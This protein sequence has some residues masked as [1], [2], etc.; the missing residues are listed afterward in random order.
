MCL[1]LRQSTYQITIVKRACRGVRHLVAC[2]FAYHRSAISMRPERQWPRVCVAR[3]R[4]LNRRRH[5]H[6]VFVPPRQPV[7][8]VAP[9]GGMECGQ[10]ASRVF[11]RPPSPPC[12]EPRRSLSSTGTSV[13]SGQH[14]AVSAGAASPP[15]AES[16]DSASPSAFATRSTRF[17][18]ADNLATRHSIRTT[19]S[20]RPIAWL[21]I[22]CHP[23]VVHPPPA[24]AC[25]DQ[26]L[27]PK[28]KRTYGTQGGSGGKRWKTRLGGRRGVRR[29]RWRRLGA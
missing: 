18:P 24:D 14:Y 3:R 29:T 11:A 12:P 17:A 15:S 26:D 7:L 27:L 16:A 5:A 6:R 9:L 21:P 25:G 28:L 22:L 20:L 1:S 10:L 4:A 23:N 19:P 8:P 13:P 2:S